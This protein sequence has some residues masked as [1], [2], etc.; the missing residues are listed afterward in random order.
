MGK[1]ASFVVMDAQNYYDALN[2]NSPVLASYRNGKK[3]A[4]STPGAKTALF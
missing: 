2:Y 3:I 4:E 1:P